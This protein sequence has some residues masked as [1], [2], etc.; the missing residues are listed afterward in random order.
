[1]TNDNNNT[2]ETKTV[3]VV[4]Y[5]DRA[6]GQHSDDHGLLV[7]LGRYAKQFP[8]GEREEALKGLKVT[9]QSWTLSEAQDYTGD[10][11][12]ALVRDKRAVSE[13]DKLLRQMERI[14]R[15]LEKLQS[16]DELD[17]AAE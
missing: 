14:Q 6:P 2:S 11:V 12:M 1:M 3:Y 13:E 10:A 15:R 5:Q 8:E 7:A 9:R 17:D 4:H 16:L